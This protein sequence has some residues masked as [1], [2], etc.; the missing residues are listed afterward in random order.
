MKNNR[1]VFRFPHIFPP[2]HDLRV[3]QNLKDLPAHVLGFCQLLA[4]I[5][6]GIYF[7]VL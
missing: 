7:A 3:C 5:K 4:E 2:A 6:F 1:C